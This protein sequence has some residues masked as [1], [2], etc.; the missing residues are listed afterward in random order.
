MTALHWASKG[1]HTDCLV[2]I[3]DNLGTTDEPTEDG[4]WTPL[5]LAAS[6]GRTECLQILLR[7][8]A[9]INRTNDEGR[10][11]IQLAKTEETTQACT[12]LQPFSV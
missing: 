9:D 1:G 8:G 3:L 5:H 11:A 12:I 2:V 10:T 4:G 7:N 6:N